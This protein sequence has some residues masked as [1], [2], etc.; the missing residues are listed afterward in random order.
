MSNLRLIAYSSGAWPCG[1]A[2]Y[3]SKLSRGLSAHLSC[4]TERLPTGTVYRDQPLALLA[5]RRQYVKM[6]SKS[7]GY[8]AALINLVTQW[9]GSRAGEHMLPA[10]MNHL[11]GPL[12][13]IVHE[14]PPLPEQEPLTGSLPRR[15][16][17]AAARAASRLERRG[18]PFEQWL[19][20]KLFGRAAHMLVHAEAL[21]DKLLS[22]GVPAERVTFR[23]HP[24]PE[25]AEP[26]DTAFADSLTQRFPN[27]RFI[28]LFG[29]PH[30]RKSLELAVQA[31]PQLP[32][33]VMLLFVGGIDGDF[34][35][36]Y[37]QSLM[38]TAECLWV[39]DRV[40][41]VGEVPEP[42]LAATLS[43]AAFALAPFSYATG[44]G[45]FSY[46]MAAG[47]P[48]VATDLPEHQALVRDGAGI[49]LFE[50]GN[51]GALLRAVNE[52]LGDRDKRQA[53]AAQNRAFANRHTYAGLAALIHERVNE[54]VTAPSQ[55]HA[56]RKPAPTPL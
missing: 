14:W 31:L 44:S 46:L 48:I 50:R 45:S 30:P 52:L 16:I 55:Q 24:V 33:D 6:A 18:L 40:A 22:A 8:D 51:G 38:E 25:L 39:R 15:A 56:H 2:D 28:V 53:L 13:L 43:L 54:M 11:R 35:R 20:Q 4:D 34:R 27:R 36:Q 29:F 32:P 3:H 41:F 47:V 26:G 23:I 42:S 9:N 49:T 17:V 5:R 12:F 10:F 21:R 7:R 37:V 1:I 19:Q